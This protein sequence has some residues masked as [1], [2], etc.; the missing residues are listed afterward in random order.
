M[1]ADWEL[2]PHELAMLRELVRVI[3]ALDRLH[4]IVK[5]QGVTIDS[6]GGL[7]VHPALVEARQL[8]IAQ[9]RLTAALRLPD[10]A[11]GDESAGRRQRRVGARGV[12]GLRAVS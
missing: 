2:E 5:R 4:A 3:D 7:K 12:Y 11:E 6:P 10:G 9:A 8:G 1:L